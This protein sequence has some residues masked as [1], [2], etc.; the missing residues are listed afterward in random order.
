MTEYSN[1]QQENRERKEEVNRFLKNLSAFDLNLDI[2]I[3]NTPPNWKEREEAK[4]TALYIAGNPNLLEQLTTSNHF[5]I[6]AWSEKPPL[7]LYKLNYLKPYITAVALLLSGD[8]PHLK[9][10]LLPCGETKIK[11]TVL[12]TN[13]KSITILKDTGE[14]KTMRWSKPVTVGQEIAWHDYRTYIFYTLAALL[15]FILVSLMFYYLLTA[16]R[17]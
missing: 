8:Y 3:E 12:K 16:G 15:L 10:Y 5:S 14:F 11:A 2:L 1:R 17:L 4:R 9:Q 7:S 6:D 13:G